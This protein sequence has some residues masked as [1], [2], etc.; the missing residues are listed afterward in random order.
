[1]LSV[2]VCV[3]FSCEGFCVLKEH[4]NTVVGKIELK[5]ESLDFP[6]AIAQTLH[7][8]QKYRALFYKFLNT[9]WQEI[10]IT[11]ARQNQLEETA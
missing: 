3:V 8:T 2:P 4:K 10:T 6:L 9:N 5:I 11:S 7:F 1:M